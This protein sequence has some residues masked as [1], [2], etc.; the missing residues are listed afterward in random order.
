M[1][2]I[3]LM[4]GITL[5]D[6][7]MIREGLAACYALERDGRI[8][9]IETGTRNSVPR[10][11]AWLADN[12]YGRDQVDYVIATHVHLDH[13]G[14]V[15][16]LMQEIEG[17]TLVIHPRGARH[18][19]QPAKLQ[20]GATAVY[21][22]EAYQQM[23]GDLIPVSE[24]RMHIAEDGS[25]LTLGASTLTFLD[26]P[27]HANHHFCVHESVSN[28]FFTGDTFG[29]AYRELLVEGRPFIF[30]SSTPVQF[31]PEALKAS[32]QRMLE[33]GTERMFLTHYGMVEEPAALALELYEQIDGYVAICDEVLAQMPEAGFERGALIQERLTEFT[34]ARA[35]AHGCEEATA[36]EHIAFDMGL[37]A[38]G[39][40]V[41]LAGRS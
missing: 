10:I 12:S 27:G 39:L 16:L 24:D 20:A 7:G 11:L 31:N 23:Y 36:R 26:T 29:I 9:I 17:A 40:E 8:A 25:T 22:E 34:L 3:P 5:I 14:G 30:P 2:N 19:A 21:G 37:N 28:G 38:Q 6:S 33:F 13:A 18:M 15:G 4:D 1:S 32:I 41:W 35:L